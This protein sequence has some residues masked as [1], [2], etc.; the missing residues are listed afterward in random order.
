MPRSH[1]KLAGILARERMHVSTRPITVYGSD[2]RIEAVSLR[3][4]RFDKQV[5]AA[6]KVREITKA[7]KVG[8]HLPRKRDNMA[9]NLNIGV[10]TRRPRDRAPWMEAGLIC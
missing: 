10:A 1:G 6:E 9:A 2:A 7:R 3:W 5:D 4:K 8:A